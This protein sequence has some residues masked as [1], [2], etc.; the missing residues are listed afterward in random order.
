M[1]KNNSLITE[2]AWSDVRNKVWQSCNKLGK[3]ID[4]IAPTKEYSLWQIHYPF[5]AKI[6]AENL[7]HL[8]NSH[9]TTL[10]I[11]DINVPQKVRDQLNYSPLPLGIISENSVEK[12]YA[13]NNKI[14]S[15]A[16]YHNDLNLG[17]EEHFGWTSPYNIVSGA[18]SLY[19][20]PKISETI[21]HKKLKK[22]FGISATPPKRLVD[23]W[24]V[25]TQLASSNKFPR[26]W[27][28]ELIFLSN[29]WIDRLKNDPAWREL[30]LYLWQQGWQHNNYARN[31]AS[32]A[33]IQEAFIQQLNAKNLKFDSYITDT[34]NHLL[35]IS[36]GTL[37]ANAPTIDSNT[38]GPIKEIQLIYEEIYK[39]ANI[40]TIM[41]PKYFTSL[42]NP[43]YYSLQ[44]PTLLESATK[45]KQATSVIEIIRN[46]KEL[47]DYFR[48]KPWISSHQTIISKINF[49]FFHSDLFAYGPNIR[50]STEMLKYDSALSYDPATSVHNFAYHSTFLRGCVRITQNNS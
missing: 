37:P 45:T 20:L 50:P 15:A 13:L 5:G 46:L 31:K 36:L 33:I 40:P 18:R 21:A 22:E 24:Q 17:I 29:K 25:F 10:P 23:H 26:P 39:L 28:C 47:I 14:F 2:V 42:D 44:N 48:E 16:F 12:Y 19:M 43:V 3:I 30:N 8:P 11:T 6:F 41:Q 32:L 27:H 9:G 7:L 4:A 49:D 34:L 35:L 1:Q 38:A